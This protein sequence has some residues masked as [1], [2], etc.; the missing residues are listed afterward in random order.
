MTDEQQ[1]LLGG[2]K[3]GEHILLNPAMANRHGLITGATG[4][5]KTVTLQLLAEAFSRLGVPVFSADVKG[6]LSGIANPGKTHE[7]ITERLD[8]MGIT[9]YPFEGCPTLFWDIAGKT[10][11]PVRTTISEM[12]P[13]LLANILELN[14]T[15]SGILHVAFSVADDEGLLLLDLKDLSSCLH[16]IAENRKELAREYGNIASQSVSAMQRKLLVLK[17][18]GGD[19]FFGQPALNIEDLMH[20]DFSGRGVVSLLDAS[21]LYSNPR[22][23]STF[24]LWL[25]SELMEDLPER[26]DAPLPRLVFFFDEAHLLF[27]NSPKSLIE[28]ITQVVRLIRSKGVGIFFVTQYPNDIPDEVLG[29]LGCRIQH[30]LRAFTPKDQKAVKVAA[31]TFRQNPEIDTVQTITELGVGE[32]L[33]ST[34]DPKGR[35]TMVDWCLLAPPH[36][37]IGPITADE[38]ARLMDRSP[39]K[40]RYDTPVD[41]ESAYE[42]LIAREEELSK[43]RQKAAIELEIEKITAKEEKQKNKRPGRQRQTA[44]EA[45]FKSIARSIGSQLGRTIVRGIL[46]SI[47]GKR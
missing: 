23:Y 6:D 38:K 20:A 40:G 43:K 24:L 18:S 3:T 16:W 47:T 39:I 10:G 15:Q 41:R 42:L 13:V 45:M 19:V 28:R 12:G 11:H 36:S 5:G 14:E 7:K 26:G 46:G 31:Q 37:Q 35:P 25:L 30:A 4:T 8:H 27:K 44:G 17:E 29:Q 1:V 2:N 32:A 34:L 22:I 9:D 33:I 21:S